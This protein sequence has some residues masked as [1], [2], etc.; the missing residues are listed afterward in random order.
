MAGAAQNIKPVTL[1]L[2]GNSPVV[3]CEDADL[4][5]ASLLGGGPHESVPQSL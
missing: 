5:E 1:E 2:G 4:E 3:V